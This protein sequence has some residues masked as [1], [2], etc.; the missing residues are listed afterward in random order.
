MQPLAPLPLSIHPFFRP[1]TSSFTLASFNT[2]PVPLLPSL[3]PVLESLFQASAPFLQLSLLPCNFTSLSCWSLFWPAIYCS[4]LFISLRVNLLFVLPLKDA[5]PPVRSPGPFS[6]S[7]RRFPPPPAP[8]SAPPSLTPRVLSALL[9]PSSRSHNS[10]INTVSSEKS[11]ATSAPSSLTPSARSALLSPWF[12]I[13]PHVPDITPLTYPCPRSPSPPCAC[14]FHGAT[15]HAVL[16]SPNAFVGSLSRPTG[17]LPSPRPRTRPSPLVPAPRAA[18]VLSTPPRSPS[19]F[20]LASSFGFLLV[21]SLLAVP[22]VSLLS[23]L[24]ASAMVLVLCLAGVVSLLLLASLSLLAFIWL[25]TSS[26]AKLRVTWR[27]LPLAR[28]LT[29][30]GFL[31]PWTPC[32]GPLLPLALS[33]LLFRAALVLRALRRRAPLSSSAASCWFPHRK[34]PPLRLQSLLASPFLSFSRLAGSIPDP[35]V[36]AAQRRRVRRRDHWLPGTL[37]QPPLTAGPGFSSDP[38]GDG[39]KTT[40]MFGGSRQALTLLAQDLRTLFSLSSSPLPSGWWCNQGLHFTFEE[41]DALALLAWRHQGFLLLFVHNGYV[42]TCRLGARRDSLLLPAFLVDDGGSAPLP[43]PSL[44]H[45]PLGPILGFAFSHFYPQELAP[46]LLDPAHVPSVLASADLLLTTSPVHSVLDAA[47]FSRV[48]IFKPAGLAR[49]DA[50]AAIESAWSSSPLSLGHPPNF[51]ALLLPHESMPIYD[52]PELI[53]IVTVAWESNPSP[54]ALLAMLRDYHTFCRDH[55]GWR[56]ALPALTSLRASGAMVPGSAAAQA[57][58]LH[59][60]PPPNS[61]SF[62][63]IRTALL[64]ASDAFLVSGDTSPLPSLLPLESCSDCARLNHSLAPPGTSSCF[65]GNEPFSD[66]GAVPRFS[67][68]TYASLSVSQLLLIESLPSNG[69]VFRFHLPSFHDVAYR[70]FGHLLFRHP[71]HPSPPS[72][73]PAF[74]SDGAGDGPSLLLSSLFF[75]A[76]ALLLSCAC[77]FLHPSPPS[78]GPAFPSDVAGDGPTPPSLFPPPPSSGP[79]F[80]SCDAGDGPTT[81]FFNGSP[82]ALGFLRSDFAVLFSLSSSPLPEFVPSSE[83]TIAA[84]FAN[85]DEADALLACCHAG[86][87]TLFLHNEY[88]V[89]CSKEPSSSSSEAG[90]AP[91][92]APSPGSAPQG[93]VLEFTFTSLTS[94]ELSTSALARHRPALLEGAELRLRGASGFARFPSASDLVSAWAR[95]PLGLGHTSYAIML[96]PL[97][98][99]PPVPGASAFVE[100]A[101]GWWG[102]E[103]WSAI[104]PQRNPDAL[105]TLIREYL[106]CCPS[107]PGLAVATDTIRAL[108]AVGA[109]VPGSAAAQHLL[110]FA[111]PPPDDFSTATSIRTALLFAPD[112]FFEAALTSSLLDLL[113]VSACSACS[114]L[115]P[116]LSF[117]KASP[118]YCSM[119]CSGA[120]PLPAFASSA[121]S[122]ATLSTEVEELIASLP[123]PGAPQPYQPPDWPSTS[124]ASSSSVSSTAASATSVAS[125]SLPTAASVA[126]AATSA[127]QLASSASAA[128]SVPWPSLRPPFS[129]PPNFVPSAATLFIRLSNGVSW[130]EAHPRLREYGTVVATM[131][132]APKS[133]F[134]LWASAQAAERCLEDRSRT[135]AKRIRASRLSQSLPANRKWVLQK[136]PLSSMPPSLGPSFSI[137][138]PSPVRSGSSVTNARFLATFL[139]RYAGSPDPPN[140][141]VSVRWPSLSG[142][143]HCSIQ[144]ALADACLLAIRSDLVSWSAGSV[145]M[146]LFGVRTIFS[147]STSAAPAPSATAAAASTSTAA[148]APSATAAAAS[149]PTAA[150][151]PSATAAAASTS[152]AAAASTS[153]TAAPSA[154]AAASSAAPAA[155]T[156]WGSSPDASLPAAA[157]PSSAFLSQDA[158]PGLLSTGA[159]PDVNAGSIFSR[160]PPSRRGH[161]S[162]FASCFCPFTTFPPRQ[163]LLSSEDKW[164]ELFPL[165]TQMARE[166]NPVACPPPFSRATYD[167]NSCISTLEQQPGGIQIIPVSLAPPGNRFL[168]EI[169]LLPGVRAFFP[170]GG[171]AL[172]EAYRTLA[173]IF[174]SVNPAPALA[175]WDT[176]VHSS[177]LAGAIRSVNLLQS[178]LHFGTIVSGP[179]PPEGSEGSLCFRG[180]SNWWEIHSPLSRPLLPAWNEVELLLSISSLSVDSDSVTLRFG[181]NVPSTTVGVLDLVM[182]RGG[183]APLHGLRAESLVTPAFILRFS[184]PF[185]ATSHA[186][187]KY[188]PSHPSSLSPLPNSPHSPP[189]AAGTRCTVFS[190]Q[191]RINSSMFPISSPASLATNT[192][193]SVKYG[194]H[195]SF[196]PPSREAWLAGPPL[197][198]APASE[199]PFPTSDLI[200]AL[201]G[202]SITCAAPALHLSPSTTLSSP[203]SP[204]IYAALYT[205]PIQIR[206]TSIPLLIRHGG[207]PSADRYII[208]LCVSSPP[209]DLRAGLTQLC[210]ALS[211]CL[212]ESSTP[213]LVE[214]AH[215]PLWPTISFNSPAEARACCE[216]DLPPG[217]SLVR[218]P[219]YG[220]PAGGVRL[221]ISTPGVLPPHLCVLIARSLGHLRNVYLPR[222]P[223]SFFHVVCNRL[224]SDLEATLA[225]FNAT[226]TSADTR[227]PSPNPSTALDSARLD[228]VSEALGALHHL[229][230]MQDGD[231]SLN[232]NPA[233][234]RLVEQI[235]TSLTA[236]RAAPAP[237]LPPP[238]R[239]RADV[240]QTLFVYSLPSSLQAAQLALERLTSSAVSSHPSLPLTLRISTTPPADP[241]SATLAAARVAPPSRILACPSPP[242]DHYRFFSLTTIGPLSLQLLA[243]IRSAWNT[244]AISSSPSHL[245]VALLTAVPYSASLSPLEGVATSSLFSSWSPTDGSAFS[246]SIILVFGSPRPQNSLD[247]LSAHPL[248]LSSRFSSPSRHE[249][250]LR[251]RRLLPIREVVE[252]VRLHLPT[253]LVDPSHF[254]PTPFVADQRL[255][256]PLGSSFVSPAPR[257]ALRPPLSQSPASSLA[258]VSL[259]SPQGPSLARRRIA[260]PQLCQAR[261]SL[262]ATSTVYSNSPALVALEGEFSEALPGLRDGDCFFRAFLFSGAVQILDSTPHL[263]GNPPGLV[264]DWLLHCAGSISPPSAFP[265]ARD[266]LIDLL[267]SSEYSSSLITAFRARLADW[268][269]DQRATPHPVLEDRTWEDAAVP[270]DVCIADLRQPQ[271]PASDIQIT[272]AACMCVVNLRRHSPPDPAVEVVT[273]SSAPW[274]D[275]L[276]LDRHCSALLPLSVDHSKWV[277]W[278]SSL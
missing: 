33:L 46:L 193:A 251:L 89:T 231:S 243:T 111:A 139:S 39:P 195:S 204:S 191:Q 19:P 208:G 190:G 143:A 202:P 239:A 268:L 120:T 34:T 246:C 87:L 133:S 106:R 236:K 149:T 157:A 136:K 170:Q 18:R 95:S 88:I 147:S 28:R 188:S 99:C 119:D 201:A 160:P 154:T 9:P 123:S 196:T 148:P 276:L 200:T 58:L 55:P 3:R 40:L 84:V 114:R 56:E 97:W 252:A 260:L 220:T 92:P 197:T 32:W 151:A 50:Y 4:L 205:R 216:A 176:I 115:A 1:L 207:L 270:L 245:L 77:A 67:S 5:Q 64:F 65:C 256:S 173:D 187:F 14:S 162:P 30:L 69:P 182:A 110:S 96:R 57:L 130:P 156:W 8:P 262:V 138:F 145:G 230:R 206:G 43:A 72:S 127:A 167:L 169:R 266:H 212:E 52:L 273:S 59:A 219:P 174:S 267:A 185:H 68:A 20:R 41:R 258:N 90:P 12:I 210:E 29:W 48:S 128:S 93:T 107:S 131:Y 11:R 37:F 222:S 104:A 253:Q 27:D 45:P 189:L 226:S 199:H 66:P 70:Q 217:L 15:A 144:G 101:R 194:G 250:N 249:V 94:R 161:S 255:P 257:P 36:S 241:F 10:S 183:F 134:V 82:R 247:L 227:R 177:G 126:P 181:P 47:D 31:L 184:L 105:S 146:L 242:D 271:S 224:P 155:V 209:E 237:S 73:G 91:L 178:L 233:C 254:V 172:A 275:L 263:H 118:F 42:V 76:L 211:S 13:V 168:A 2:L 129:H 150:P 203:R 132:N 86:V 225:T 78:S 142:P 79:A 16:P 21:C 171:V 265:L 98:T 125:T 80:S 26:L 124:V 232:L 234:L 100:A 75:S 214:L 223:G 74:S 186:V 81:L 61:L 274:I 121:A 213:R 259:N 240:P 23:T 62:R 24:L 108:R 152:T 277:S 103:D 159:P 85:Q 44:R 192:G 272:A 51:A 165:S 235:R 153:A 49:F 113:P 248:V 25:P 180:A 35:V 215:H 166:D 264:P 63:A 112:C 53:E 175:P 117:P 179:W 269:A 6:F 278:T 22:A 102:T 228:A 60:A 116:S 158:A 238:K 163:R 244:A 218:T 135:V 261:T 164:P 221:R 71:P 229:L 140:D 141:L 17:L 7:W 137:S 109:M 198:I 83:T 122:Y 38:A 54:A